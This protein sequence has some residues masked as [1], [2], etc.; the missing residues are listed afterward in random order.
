PEICG[1]NLDNNCD[2]DT[3]PCEEDAVLYGA[4]ESD[5]MGT[6]V[7]FAGDWDGDGEEDLIIGAPK[8]DGTG[9]AM[10]AVYV[11]AGPVTGSSDVS[12]VA[13]V[14]FTGEND[15]DYVGIAVAGIG[16]VNDDDYSDIVM[17]A[18]GYDGAGGGSYESGAFYLHWGPAYGSAD[19]TTSYDVKWWGEGSYDW[20][21]FSVS[22]AGDFN[23]DGY[24]DFMVGAYKHDP[25]TF[26]DAGAAYIL[27]GPVTT[28]DVNLSYANVKLSGS[29]SSEWAGYSLDGGGD[30]NNDGFDDVIVGAPQLYSGGDYVG[31]AYVVYGE[32]EPSS[33]TSLSYADGLMTGLSAASLTGYSVAI[34]GDVNGDGYDDVLV[35]APE[36]AS[37]GNLSGSAYLVHGPASGTLSLTNADATFIAENND[38]YLGSAVSGAGDVDNNGQDDVLIGASQDDFSASDSGAAYVMLAP[39]LGSVSVTEA[40]GKLVGPN[41]DDRAGSSV[42][43]GVDM[44]DD[45][46]DDVFVGAPR[47]DDNATDG[48]AAFLV[49]GGGF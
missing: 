48:G 22:E 31:G 29:A 37:N 39:L 10:G 16:D 33:S 32:E 25:S 1:D 30:L 17:G 7:G 9:N 5:I 40:G 11:V 12:T 49:F 47:N 4:A 14:T 15:Q 43:G 44:N 13:T 27:L 6:A 2:D 46:Y 23:N 41:Y 24:L 19:L 26:T 42:I 34:A 45:G 20:A 28:T 35:G 18:Y 8:N 36:E 21:G 3:D 38:D